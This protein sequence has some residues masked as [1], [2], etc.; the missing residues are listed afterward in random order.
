MALG[1]ALDGMI[2]IVLQTGKSPF[3]KYDSYKNEFVRP[4]LEGSGAM[5]GERT[6]LS[7]IY[8]IWPNA[9]IDASHKRSI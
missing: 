2:N 6:L 4:S 3:E 1:S 7:K 9:L 5:P 8:Q